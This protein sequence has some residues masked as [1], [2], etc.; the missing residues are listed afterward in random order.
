M[1]IWTPPH[2]E[3]AFA[4]SLAAGIAASASFAM[5]RLV[6]PWFLLVDTRSYHVDR[7]RIARP[8]HQRSRSRSME[9]MLRFALFCALLSTARAAARVDAAARNGQARHGQTDHRQQLQSRA[10]QCARRA[11]GCGHRTLRAAALSPDGSPHAR[12]KR[13][14]AQAARGMRRAGHRLPDAGRERIV[15]A[16][17]RRQ[18]R[19]AQ[20]GDARRALCMAWRR[21]RNWSRRARM[22]TRSAPSI[23]KISRAFPG[24]A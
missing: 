18:W 19:D 4:R 13:C 23:S 6:Y 21:S 14:D 22:A 3:F 9:R 20:S 15:H 17:R 10:D 1:P 7:L 8:L 16:G 5:S 12:P 24:A 11:P 2:L